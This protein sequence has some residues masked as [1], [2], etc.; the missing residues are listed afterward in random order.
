MFLERRPKLRISHLICITA[1]C[2][3]CLICRSFITDSHC[4]K[5]PLQ[6]YSQ[7][8]VVEVDLFDKPIIIERIKEIKED[9]FLDHHRPEKRF[10]PQSGR[11][12]KRKKNEK[13]DGKITWRTKIGL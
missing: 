11:K 12:K 2:V 5:P 8:Q 6:K 7:V 4:I 3:P 1:P 13:G 9:V 10:H